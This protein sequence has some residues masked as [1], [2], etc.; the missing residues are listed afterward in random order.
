RSNSTDLSAVFVASNHAFEWLVAETISVAKH[1]NTQLEA[2][3]FLFRRNVVSFKHVFVV[4]V[5]GF[6]ETHCVEGFGND[7]CVLTNLHR[8]VD[9]NMVK[10]N[11]VTSHTSSKC[12]L[13]IRAEN[14]RRSLVNC[15]RTPRHFNADH[16][17]CDLQVVPFGNTLLVRNQNLN[18]RFRLETV[19]QLLNVGFLTSTGCVN[20]AF[21]YGGTF[22]D[23]HRA[24]E[25]HGFALV[26]VRQRVINA[27]RSGVESSD[28]DNLALRLQLPVI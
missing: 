7:P 5:A 28:N 2:S 9:D 27:M 23:I 10:V 13:G 16:S 8:L 12:T 3:V 26:L 21:R 15:T 14:T 6:G 19:E 20:H 24:S 18:I 17:V 25:H 4:G 1:R 11:N 22:L